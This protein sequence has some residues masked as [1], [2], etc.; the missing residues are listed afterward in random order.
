MLF[1]ILFIPFKFILIILLF[2]LLL[3]LL[4][5]ILSFTLAIW[6]FRLI[7]TFSFPI[8]FVWLFPFLWF[9]YN[10]FSLSSDD[11]FECSLI[12]AKLDR[13]SD[14][15]YGG[16]KNNVYIFSILTSKQLLLLLLDWSNLM[17]RPNSRA[18]FELLDNWMLN[19]VK[20]SLSFSSKRDLRSTAWKLYSRQLSNTWY[21]SI[22]PLIRIVIMLSKKSPSYYAV[23]GIITL[24]GLIRLKNSVYSV[25]VYFWNKC[26]LL[27]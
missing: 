9:V 15:Y 2:I 5:P 12:P 23:N 6:L 19:W 3:K 21:C 1:P 10:K 14:V 16:T 22:L 18:S 27:L 17:L 13:S 7:R 11:S 25:S 20:L 4:I 24:K 26:I 8:A